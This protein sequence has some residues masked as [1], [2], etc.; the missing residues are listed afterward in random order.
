MFTVFPEVVSKKNITF[1]NDIFYSN[2][3]MVIKLAYWKMN[4]SKDQKANCVQI[5]LVLSI[6]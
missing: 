4:F 2:I 3:N 5:F 6:K 1:G